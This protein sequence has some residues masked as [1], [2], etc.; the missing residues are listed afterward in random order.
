MD[1]APCLPAAILSLNSTVFTT[2]RGGRSSASD[3]V[4]VVT[5]ANTP[6]DYS[7]WTSAGTAALRAGLDVRVVGIGNAPYLIALRALTGNRFNNVFRVN[8]PDN[9]TSVV[10][11]LVND[12]CQPVAV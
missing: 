7:S 6:F 2:P 5:D 10:G 4:I 1:G 8:G 3:V 11:E 12:L 9:V